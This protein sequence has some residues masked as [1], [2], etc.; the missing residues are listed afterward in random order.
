MLGEKPSG[1][2]GF[3]SPGNVVEVAG[4]TRAVV[5]GVARGER[6]FLRSEGL[7]AFFASSFFSDGLFLDGVSGRPIVSQVFASIANGLL[8]GSTLDAGVKSVMY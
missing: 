7:S 2:V 4:S 8:P 1:N 3:G 5:V 6:S